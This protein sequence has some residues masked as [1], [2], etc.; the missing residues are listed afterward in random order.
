MEILLWLV[1]AAVVTTVAMIWAAWAGRE[2]PTMDE[3]SEA[4][5][6]EAQRRLAEAMARPH[7]HATPLVRRQRERSTGVAIRHDRSA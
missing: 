7:P 6:Q 3:R 2:R 1:P 4:A 5:R